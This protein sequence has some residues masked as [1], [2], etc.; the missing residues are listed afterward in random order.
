MELKNEF[1]R[2]IER[3]WQGGNGGRA[4]SAVGGKLLLDHGPDP[5]FLVLCAE[6][7][8]LR[9]LIEGQSPAFHLPGWLV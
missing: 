4:M 8:S 2:D 1:A 6:S 5:R 9:F 7:R 3:D